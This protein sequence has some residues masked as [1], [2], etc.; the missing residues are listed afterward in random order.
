MDRWL[1]R[2]KVSAV[3]CR[4][5]ICVLLLT[6]CGMAE[7]DSEN[8]PEGVEVSDENAGTDIS[9]DKENMTSD[10]ISENTEEEMGSSVVGDTESVEDNRTA[11][12]ITEQLMGDGRFEEKVWY[13]AGIE[14]EDTEELILQKLKQCESLTLSSKVNAE[15]LKY[16]YLLPNLRSLE[17]DYTEINDFTPIAQLSQLKHLYIYHV[18]YK[19]EEVDFSFL[20]EMNTVTELYLINCDL[21]DASFLEKMPQLQCL[22]LYNTPVYDLAVLENMPELVELSLYGNREAEHIEAVGS[23][24]KM[25][26]L[27]LQ[28]CG[29][30][31]ISFLSS[32]TELRGVNL[33]YNSVAD[34]SPLTGLSKLERLGLAGNEVSD[35]S[36]VA[37]LENLY[38]LALDGNNISDISALAKL[39]RLNQA[40]LSNNQIRD[41]SPLADKPELL[42]ASVYGNP[43]TDL[44]PVEQAPLLYF[45]S[46]GISE[47]QL[48]IVS[49]WMEKQ[50]PDVEEYQC[51]DFSEADL[52]GDGL[53]DA[54]FVVN[55]EFRDGDGILAYNDSRRMFIL[56]RQRD[57]SW[58]EL[59]TDIRVSNPESGG[60]RG[61]PYQGMW[62]GDGQVL[63]KQGSGSSTGITC[64][65][66]YCYQQ[67][68]LELQ[69]TVDVYD[70]NWAYG[71]DVRVHYELDETWD[72]Y[73]IAMEDYRMVKVDIANKEYPTHRAFPRMDLY[74][75]TYYTYPD[76]L[77]VSMDGVA[78]LEYFRL[79]IRGEV[80]Q[81]PLPYAAWQKEGYELLKGVELP[82]YYYVVRK[83][84]DGEADAQED[85]IYYLDLE[86]DDGEYYHVICYE[87]DG[88]SQNYRIK[89]STGELE[90]SR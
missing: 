15:E 54:A 87:R 77:S 85:Y 59:E 75:G 63:L 41:F 2:R 40:G 66:I 12:E 34:L 17:I 7:T 64:T 31:D 10:G 78:A 60:T 56:L 70:C 30:S 82:D 3:L 27:G 67:G 14:E 11:R 58:K 39:S 36:P 23:L 46:G 89:D 35:L 86:I 79:Y 16:L 65:E 21:K 9:G 26:D 8:V 74:Y 50:R 37:G 1:H 90:E 47:E 33:N 49:D 45:G 43:C 83:D 18:D 52:N 88:R 42:Y 68:S 71:Y 81:E 57:G 19:R 62:M 72:R 29:I 20:A 5:M 6:G 4:I 28:D 25:Q 24:L 51:I 69:Q 73:A 48:K 44:G 32:L 55:G 13:A 80:E 61:D 22:S 84:G 76:G 38:D 53:S